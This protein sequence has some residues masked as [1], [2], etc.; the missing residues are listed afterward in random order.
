V[1]R[2]IRTAIAAGLIM[3]A[4]AASSATPPPIIVP[5][6]PERLQGNTFCLPSAAPGQTACLTAPPGW[7]WFEAQG[8]NVFH[9]RHPD[10]WVFAVWP[11]ERRSLDRKQLKSRLRGKDVKRIRVEDATVPERGSLLFSY[12]LVRNGKVVLRAT[13][14]ATPSLWLVSR[15]ATDPHATEFSAFLASYS[16]R[17]LSRGPRS[18][19]R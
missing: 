19:Q 17:P 6:A 2:R 15:T 16:P 8:M 14:T 13:G 5:V 9:C 1:E 10:G 3:L 7:A 18:D 4:A 11:L 12:D